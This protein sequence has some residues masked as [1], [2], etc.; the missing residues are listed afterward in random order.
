MI[1]VILSILFFVLGILAHK[2]WLY[3]HIEG[4]LEIEHPNSE[5]DKV[6]IRIDSQNLTEKKIVVLEVK[7][8][9]V[10]SQEEQ[11]LL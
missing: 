1:T 8:N 3:M 6:H 4:V 5:Y 10:I 9:V 2:M 11:G 7:D